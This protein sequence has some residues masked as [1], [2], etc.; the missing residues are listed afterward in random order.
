MAAKKIA[1]N[2]QLGPEINLE[3]ADKLHR[4]HDNKHS[5]P[6]DERTVLHR[7]T[8]THYHDTVTP[9]SDQIKLLGA[10]VYAKLAG[11]AT[12]QEV[13][14]GRL[15]IQMSGQTWKLEMNGTGRLMLSG[16]PKHPNLIQN[17]GKLDTD[18]RIETSLLDIAD[19]TV[20]LINHSQMQPP[21]SEPVFFPSVE[22]TQQ[23]QGD[24]TGL[25]PPASDPF[26]STVPP[27]SPA[28]PSAPM[29]DLA[30]ASTSQ[31]TTPGIGQPAPI[32]NAPPNVNQPTPSGFDL[33]AAGGLPSMTAARLELDD[34][35][36]QVQELGMTRL[37][38][39]LDLVSNT[40]ERLYCGTERRGL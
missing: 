7:K 26:A 27:S 33:G 8:P 21:I 30:S 35:A 13:G 17:V 37:A 9:R 22:Q 31:P 6:P 16:F 20:E 24:S 40:L 34:L 5:F 32:T 14:P 3:K 2:R 12:V 18:S 10:A 39:R 15:K 29:G 23:L 1:D 11:T 4:R 19:K 36:D 28:M 38:T 25:P